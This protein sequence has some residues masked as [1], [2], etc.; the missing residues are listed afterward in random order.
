M[1]PMGLSARL[2]SDPDLA[3]TDQK[4]CILIIANDEGNSGCWFGGWA[5]GVKLHS[6]AHTKFH[7][8]WSLIRILL[9]MV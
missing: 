3:K 9:K 1:G 8:A 2:V 4:L 7:S 6:A 5:Y